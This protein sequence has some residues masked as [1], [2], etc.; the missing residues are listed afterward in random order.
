M[1]A[2]YLATAA[3]FQ[4]QNRYIYTLVPFACLLAAALYQLTPLKDSCLRVC[5]NPTAVF[6]RDWRTGRIGPLRMGVEHGRFCIGSSWAL[7]AVLFAIGVMDV[8]LMF[9]VAGL[10][11]AEKL[12]PWRAAAS[13]GIA[14]LLAVLALAVALAPE[15]V[16]GLTIPG[17]HETTEEMS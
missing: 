9:F 1:L 15:E 6:R 13:R 12:L 5:R 10:I 3:L 16:P 14:A 7:M 2:I 4:A 17:S 11:A 8:G